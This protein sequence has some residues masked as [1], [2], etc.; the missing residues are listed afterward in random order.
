MLS[1]R[2][3]SRRT[4]LLMRTGCLSSSAS[5]MANR[6]LYCHKYL[7][8]F[9]ADY[10][11]V[12]LGQLIVL[13]RLL[14]VAKLLLQGKA[15]KDYGTTAFNHLTKM[16]SK[17]VLNVIEKGFSA[18]WSDLDMIWFKVGFAKNCQL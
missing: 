1:P 7:F 15:A 4:V 16:K 5:I 12:N 10:Y 17:I 8:F 18:L 14:F 9:R 3:T 6:G 2:L 13:I 11:H